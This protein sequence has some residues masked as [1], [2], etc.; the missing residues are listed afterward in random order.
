MPKFSASF[1]VSGAKGKGVQKVWNF[2]GEVNDHLCD[3]EDKGGIS[4][5]FIDKLF[6]A[7][8]L[9]HHKTYIQK[10]LQLHWDICDKMKEIFENDGKK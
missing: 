6:I 1:F 10:Q 5:L 7:N 2:K 9:K 3:G 4:R 8:N